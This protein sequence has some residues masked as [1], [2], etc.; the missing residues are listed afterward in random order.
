MKKLTLVLAAMIGSGLSFQAKAEEA[1]VAEYRAMMGDDSPGDFWVEDGEALFKAPSGPKNVSLEKCDFGKGPGVVAG[2]YAELPRYFKDVD[3]VMDLESRLMHCMQ[4]LQGKEKDDIIKHAFSKP[5]AGVESD[6]EKLVSYIAAQSNGMKFNLTLS[7]PKEMEAYKAGEALFWRRSGTMDF[8]CATC[9]AADDKRIRLQSLY[10]AYNDKK[11][12]ASWPT[13]R[14]SQQTVRTMQHR[15]WDCH[16]QMRLPDVDY[17]SPATIGLIT[18]M[19][20]ES[21]GGEIHVPSIKR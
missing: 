12:M 5:K 9:H 6:M 13:Y 3:Q 7:H 1:S 20:K 8:S 4:T 16:W 19:T 15:M 17:G 14:V 2:V 18:F 10:N 11:T 21:N